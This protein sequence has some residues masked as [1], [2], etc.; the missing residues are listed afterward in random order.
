M[1]QP[2]LAGQAATTEVAA[3]DL[4]ALG[5]WM[6]RLTEIQQPTL[7]ALGQLGPLWQSA[8][9]GGTDVEAFRTR[10]A[11]IQ[12]MIVRA[13]DEIERMPAPD[14]R[15][16]IPEEIRPASLRDNTLQINR[17][18]GTAL[19]EFVPALDAARRNDAAAANSALGKLLESM[20][21]VAEARILLGRG[22][23]AAMPRQSSAW[24][25]ANVELLLTR[26]LSRLLGAWPEVSAA[27]VDPTLSRDLLALADAFAVSATE[28]E[29]K[30]D[31]EAA[32][33]AQ[34]LAHAQRAGDRAAVTIL[35]RQ[36]AILPIVRRYFALARQL[37][38][39]LREQAN[40]SADR[41]LRPELYMTFTREFQVARTTIEQIN[42]Q[43]SAAL[44]GQN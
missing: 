1:A 4:T 30:C 10:I 6:V 13:S 18:L 8:V 21:L 38:T 24:D 27:T 12:V 26:T 5:R 11:E 16:G 44:A 15:I 35:R 36:Q 3:S 43:A 37:S 42:R 39:R 32:E 40:A 34:R 14:L 2:A 19:G 25:A 22:M 17:Q 41:P 7:D 20:R 23:Q 31:R 33:S 28:G 9:S 29:R